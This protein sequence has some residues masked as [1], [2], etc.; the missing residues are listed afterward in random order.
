MSTLGEIAVA[1]L[2]PAASLLGPNG[3]QSE[4]VID[5]GPM[6]QGTIDEERTTRD[7]M[8]GGQDVEITQQITGSTAE[9]DIRYPNPSQ[10][11]LGKL[12]SLDGNSRRVAEIIRGEA[13]TTITVNGSEEAP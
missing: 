12:S 10:D 13:F 9:F 6:W 1:A 8:D 5:G 3:Q 4:L 7:Y 2:R 11:Y